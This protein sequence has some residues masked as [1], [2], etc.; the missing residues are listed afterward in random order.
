[1]RGFMPWRSARRRRRC[2]RWLPP[3]EEKRQPPEEELK[4]FELRDGFE[5]NLFASEADGLV[6]P[7]QFAW[8]ERGRVVGRCARRAIRS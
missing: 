6:K 5:M 2:P 7:I 1:M 4:A 8:D 3:P